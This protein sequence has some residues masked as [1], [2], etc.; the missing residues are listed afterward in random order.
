MAYGLLGTAEEQ[1]TGGTPWGYT[2]SHLEEPGKI[3]NN[4]GGTSRS[5]EESPHLLAS[6]PL[7][8]AYLTSVSQGR[9]FWSF[10]WFQLDIPICIRKWTLSGV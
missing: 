3:Q 4:Q 5:S 1:A 10:D 9:P 7:T 8:S 6:K 2:Q